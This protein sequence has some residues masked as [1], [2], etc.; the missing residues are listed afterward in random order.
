MLA[1]CNAAQLLFCTGQD[2]GNQHEPS[3]YH[4]CCSQ[5]SPTGGP[6]PVAACTRSDLRRHPAVLSQH[7]PVICRRRLV[8][9]QPLPGLQLLGAQPAA[10][11]PLPRAPC[12]EHRARGPHSFFP[13][14]LLMPMSPRSSEGAKQTQ[15]RQGPGPPSCWSEND[16][17]NLLSSELSS[18][19]IVSSPPP[20]L[21]PGIPVTP[22]ELQT[23][24]K[25]DLT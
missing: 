24:T 21:T 19:S 11:R 22:P 18:P 8:S 9:W 20:A 23:P 14:L 7:V 10:T 17:I 2:T 16:K 1:R 6:R 15:P 12:P 13:Q 4:A 25:S 5:A 3:C